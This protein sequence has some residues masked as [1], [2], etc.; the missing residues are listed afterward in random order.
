MV[1]RTSIEVARNLAE[2]HTIATITLT[3]CISRLATGIQM[4]AVEF[5]T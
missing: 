4:I 2:A 3:T 5:K 1:C